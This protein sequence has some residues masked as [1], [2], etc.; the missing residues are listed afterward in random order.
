M[1]VEWP[2]QLELDNQNRKSIIKRWPKGTTL[3]TGGSMLQ[4][5]DEKRLFTKKGKTVKVRPFSGATVDCMMDYIKPL[6]RKAPENVILHV[7]TNS[8]VGE[9]SGVILNKLLL[10]K[11]YIE[12]ELPGCKVFLSNV[13]QRTDDTSF[14]TVINDLNN[15]LD[16]LNLE[17]IDN[18]NIK[19]QHLEKKG[20]H[21]NHH[22]AGRLA[23]NFMK[24]LK[25]IN[26]KTSK[27]H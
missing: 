4:S 18:S 27:T 25:K 3:I 5:I 2:N 11:S 10:L 15:L 23:L 26:S 16:S 13:I 9:N 12:K 21:L 14:Q 8:S 19:A 20:L 22:G 1:L 6:L 7:G 17:I 24:V